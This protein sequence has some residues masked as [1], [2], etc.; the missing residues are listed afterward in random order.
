[1]EKKPSTVRK[2]I[3][4]DVPVDAQLP[5]LDL[6]G[7]STGLPPSSKVGGSKVDLGTNLKGKAVGKTK[8][9]KKNKGMGPGA[10]VAVYNGPL[11][12]IPVNEGVDT[13]T[14]TLTLTLALQANGTGKF[15]Q[16]FPT[17]PN[18]AIEWSDFTDLWS[19]YRT[20]ATYVEYTPDQRYNRPTTDIVVSVGAI[21]NRDANTSALTDWDQTVKH[22][23]FR[24]LSLVDPWT[25]DTGYVGTKCTP[26]VWRMDGL[27]ESGFLATTGS[28]T[29]VGA[30]KIF[31][32]GNSAG[33]YVGRYVQYWVV[34]FR[35]RF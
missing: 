7:V 27:E 20:L 30:I 33:I 11:R 6:T 12:T 13:V 19:E 22:P 2:L 10:D 3:W 25:F 4:A 32:D 21:I 26:P 8:A 18:T 28:T 14:A 31:S 17:A 34:Q 15:T 23:S 1:M 16:V 5:I 9:K 24:F 29:S 35:G